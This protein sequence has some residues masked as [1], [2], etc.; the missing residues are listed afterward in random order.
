MGWA[1]TSS[2]SPAWANFPSWCKCTPESGWKFPLSV[3]S[4]DLP[5]RRVFRSFVYQ[6][7]WSQNVQEWIGFIND[8]VRG[9]CQNCYPCWKAG[10]KYCLRF[11]S[12]FISVSELFTI[13]FELEWS[14]RYYKDYTF[15]TFVNILIY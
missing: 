4:V 13:F 9:T 1:C 14:F 8:P 6:N 7:M 11:K 2:P 5:I 12:H 10:N 3:Y 15:S